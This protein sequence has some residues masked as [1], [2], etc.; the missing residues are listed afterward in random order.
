MQRYYLQGRT[1]VYHKATLYKR[2]PL[3]EELN[4]GE[5]SAIAG[6]SGCF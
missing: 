5:N 2:N 4:A 3:A 6:L 1:S